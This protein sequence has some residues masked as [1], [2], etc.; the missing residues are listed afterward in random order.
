MAIFSRSRVH[1]NTYQFIFVVVL[2][3]ALIGS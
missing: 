1:N 3:V 2:F